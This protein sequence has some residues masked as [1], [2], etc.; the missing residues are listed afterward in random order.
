LPAPIGHGIVRLEMSDSRLVADRYR[1]VRELGRGGMGQV[2]VARDERLGREVALKT[3]NAAGDAAARDRLWREAR[4]AASVS[5]P[6]VCQL[7]DL[8]E[9]GRELFLAMELLDGEPLET[10]LERGPL[11]LDEALG[12][13]DTLLAALAALHAHGV[14]HRDL[15]P[16]NVFL[17][18]HG[19]KVLDFGLAL[20]LSADELR[21]TRPGTLVGTP[22]YMAPEQWLATPVTPATDLFVCGALLFEMLSGR[23]AFS[24]DSIGDLC[25]AVLSHHPPALS[26]GP[27]V[28]AID[29]VLRRALAKSPEERWPAART[30]AQ[31]LREARVGSGGIDSAQLDSARTEM[32]QARAVTRLMVLPFRLLR[33]DPEI[34]F[35]SFGLA[36][37]LTVGLG[38][39]PQLVV[40]SSLSAGRLAADGNPD[41][42]ALAREQ[43]VDAVLFG[44]LLRAGERVR[45]STQLVQVP[46]GAV[47]ATATAQATLADVFALQ[48]ELT[49]A[50]VSA[51]ALS[52]TPREDAQLAAAAPTSGRAYELYLRGNDLRAGVGSTSQLLAARDLY[53]GAVEADPDFAPAWA[54]LGRTYRVMGKFGHG[55]ADEYRSLARAAF[56]RALA[57]APDLPL[58]HNLYTYLEVEEPGGGLRAMRRLLGQIAAGAR[59]PQLYAGLVVALR[60][61]G[62]M[63]ASI[64]ADR[65][66][67]RLDPQAHTSVHY[68]YLLMGDYARA[69]IHDQDEVPGVRWMAL[70]EMGRVEEAIAGLREVEGLHLQGAESYW[71]RS[72]RG[73]LEGRREDVMAWISERSRGFHDPEGLYVNARPAGMVGELEGALSMLERSAAG[74]WSVWSWEHDPAWKALRGDP[75]FE[76]LVAAVRERHAEAERTFAALGGDRLL[77]LREAAAA[78]L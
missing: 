24:G 43:E 42:A 44:T 48:D 46:G 67:R 73:A 53:K 71:I 38:G 51:L 21:L 33:P 72:L 47:L 65:E 22:R 12:I 49:H 18:A 29:R 5:H 17:T 45:L 10:R 35:L 74:F 52:L 37:A 6:N 70:A 69:V 54:R 75:R 26:G 62:L 56:D 4:A 8:V 39:L 31:A 34:D 60:M 9:D 58:A 59:D 32:L 30:M 19:V 64:A 27:R 23:P 14:V 78:G 11:P 25:Q 41:L 28:E 15:K 77:G 76:A 68:T 16:S 3:V 40:R 55:D 1:I 2:W 50:V 13:A 20:P 63:E 66:A 36:D 61:C 57:L 7:Y